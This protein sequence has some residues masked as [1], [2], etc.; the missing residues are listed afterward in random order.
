MLVPRAL[1]AVL[2]HP[3]EDSPEEPPRGLT[4]EIYLY[5]SPLEVR[6]TPTAWDALGERREPLAVEME[7]SFGC[8]LRKRLHFG[9]ETRPLRDADSTAEAASGWLE[10]RFRPVTGRRSGPGEVHR[11]VDF[12]LRRPGPFVPR[13]LRLDYRR[14]GGWGGT[15]GYASASGRHHH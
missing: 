14:R 1:Q 6:L 15:F 9:P 4:E 8:L 2:L 11:L 13:W 5:G 3:G 10:L 12:P 7:L